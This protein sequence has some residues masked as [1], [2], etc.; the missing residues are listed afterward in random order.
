MPD[1]QSAFRVDKSMS[2]QI[3]QIRIAAN[4]IHFNVAVAGPRDAPS[5]LFLHG[6]PEG[7]MSWRAVMESLSEYRVYAPDLRG[8][9]ETDGPERGYDVFTL[10]DDI[11][12]LIEALGLR[13][14][15][16]VAHDWGG[17]LGWIFAHRYS[18]LIQKLIVVNCTHPKTLAR[19]VLEVEDFQTFRSFYVLFLQVPKIPELVFTTALGKKLLEFCCRMLEGQPNATGAA[20]LKELISRFQKPADIRGPINYYRQLVLSQI[21]PEKRARLAAV[22][23]NPITVPATLV[24]GER[25]WVLSEAVARKSHQDG[26]CPV[27][28]RLL[29]GVGHFVQLESP[30][31]LVAEIRRAL[32]STLGSTTCPAL[33][34]AQSNDPSDV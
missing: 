26:G 14:P 12:A 31:R 21:V 15:T 28:F 6:F 19:A 8:Y 5:I 22:Y 30:E 13:Q 33:D 29:P 25:D 27:D 3:E 17:A 2:C 1:A 18:N 10:T 32:N 7:W 23:N 16:L 9:P 20:V 4:G 24:W 34:R 11:R